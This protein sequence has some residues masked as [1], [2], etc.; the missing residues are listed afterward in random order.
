MFYTRHQ[1]VA[2][3]S[4]AQAII[5]AIQCGEVLPHG[6]PSSLDLAAETLRLELVL[7]IDAC[8]SASRVFMLDPDVRRRLVAMSRDVLAILAVGSNELTLGVIECAQDRIF[9][10]ALIQNNL[11]RSQ[12][13]RRL[14]CS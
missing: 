1:I 9:D 2:H 4:S 13:N 10:E 8:D 12:T 5:A 11:F 6:S 7:L 14:E 3:W